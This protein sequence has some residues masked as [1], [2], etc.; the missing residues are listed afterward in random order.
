[1][2]GLGS[3]TP[4]P[5]APVWLFSSGPVGDPSRKLVQS[6][7]QDPA[8]VTRIRQATGARGHRMFA[9]NSTRK[10]SLTPL[11][12]LAV[13]GVARSGPLAAAGR[14]LGSAHYGISRSG[15]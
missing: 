8:D 5:L 9:A 12:I 14:D 7:E 10:L 6:L 1:M 2:H 4:G 13:A 3:A 11:A 15:T